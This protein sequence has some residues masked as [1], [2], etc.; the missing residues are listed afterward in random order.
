[1]ETV[2]TLNKGNASIPFKFSTQQVQV[3]ENGQYVTKQIESQLGAFGKILEGYLTGINADRHLDKLTD[4]Y[5]KAINSSNQQQD[6]N[7][8]QQFQ[9]NNNYNNNFQ[10]PSG[11][12]NYN[13]KNNYRNNNGGNNNW[14]KNSQQQPMS[15][16]QLS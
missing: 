4:D 13:S 11:N 16:Y 2:L 3:K 12:Y 5:V 8:Q 9:P 15:T 6:N 14:N 7:Q 1:M 10:K